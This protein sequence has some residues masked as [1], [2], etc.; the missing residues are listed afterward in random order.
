MKKRVTVLV[1]SAV[2]LFCSAGKTLAGTE[3]S[4]ELDAKIANLAERIS[5]VP[6]MARGGRIAVLPFLE[7]QSGFAD[8]FGKYVS[9]GLLAYL[10]R[11]GRFDVVGKEL[12]DKL[13]DEQGLGMPGVSDDAAAKKEGKVLGVGVVVTGTYTTLDSRV[14]I[15]ARVISVESGTI[16]ATSETTLNRSKEVEQLLAAEGA[17]ELRALQPAAPGRPAEAL[18]KNVKGA[19]T[20]TVSLG[21]GSFLP[22][23]NILPAHHR[24]CS[25]PLHD[26]K[27]AGIVRE[28]VYT[29][30]LRKFGTM[31]LGT[32]GKNTFFFALDIT[33]GKYAAF[34]FDRNQNG[35]LTDDGGPIMNQGNPSAYFAGGLTLPFSRILDNVNFPEYRGWLFIDEAS[36]HQNLMCYYSTTQLKG[37][38]T[39]EGTSYLAYI[40]DSD[41]NDA[42]YTNDGIYID[43]NGDQRIDTTTEYISPGSAATING[44]KYFFSISAGEGN[45]R[46]I[47]QDPAIGPNELAKILK[48]TLV[49]ETKHSLVFDVEYFLSEKFKGKATIGIYPDMP[50][51]TVSATHAY[52]GRHTVSIQVDLHFDAKVKKKTVKSSTLRFEIDSYKDYSYTGEIFR[53]I[54]LFEKQWERL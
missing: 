36:W 53:R 51:W 11:T 19:T 21:D 7:L 44:K 54:V 5:A 46:I 9:K 29:G 26:I 22:V 41:V 40:V 32:T 13:L 8:P 48:V 2:L 14:K 15:S 4:A 17:V 24:G 34:Y 30:S 20:V 28:P 47:F 50:Y 25:I 33:P 52:A 38:V 35:D 45:R 27:P 3:Q 49:G 43:L 18:K 16:I 6:G 37:E 23:N 42:D 10:A 1:M 31:R 12:L 39:I